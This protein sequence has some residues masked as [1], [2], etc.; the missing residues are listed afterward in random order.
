[1]SLLLLILCTPWDMNSF[2]QKYNKG[3]KEQQISKKPTFHI[4]CSS[5]HLTSSI[6][7]QHSRFQEPSLIQEASATLSQKIKVYATI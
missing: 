3:S 7:H 5:L 2:V 1:M 6:F 4:Y